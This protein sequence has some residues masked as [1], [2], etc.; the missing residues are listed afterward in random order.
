MKNMGIVC[1]VAFILVAIGG[2]NWGL[3]GIFDFNLVSAIFGDGTMITRAIYI[4]V[5]VIALYLIFK[6]VTKKKEL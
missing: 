3:V 2:I 5:G 6:K 1:L 4:L